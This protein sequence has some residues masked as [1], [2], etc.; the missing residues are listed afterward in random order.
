MRWGTLVD[1]DIHTEETASAVS[2]WMI[3]IEAYRMP[4]LR[5]LFAARQAQCGTLET[6]ASRNSGKDEA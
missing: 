6:S 2:A 5:R 1:S 3:A 4:Q